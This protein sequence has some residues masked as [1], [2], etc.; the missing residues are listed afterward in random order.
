MEST[1][2]A[3]VP[4]D[5]GA[6]VRRRLAV[7]GAGALVAFGVLAALV[8]ARWSPLLRVDRRVADSLVGFAVRHRGYLDVLR[9]VTTVL[10]PAT[11][12]GLAGFVAVLLGLRH[13]VGEATWVV[14][15]G[16]TGWLVTNAAKVAVARPRPAAGELVR[17]YGGWSF[18]SGH[19]SN[20]ALV[21]TILAVVAAGWV[22]GR[23]LLLLRWVAVLVALVTGFSRL[24]VGAHYLCDVLAGWLLGLGWACC[25]AAVAAVRVRPP[26][27]RPPPVQ[28]VAADSPR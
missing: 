24:A 23:A 22:S 14:L 2:G 9:A 18:P 20:A 13:R 7:V 17:H 21:A 8:A 25:A 11:Y 1:V 6:R 19:A 15:T 26:F 16:G 10:R 28:D 5:H 27:T 4:T 12:L 3:P